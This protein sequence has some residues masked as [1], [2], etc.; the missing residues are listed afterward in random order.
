MLQWNS[1]KYYILLV[2]IVA[3]GNQHAMH[4][5]LIA[6]CALPSSTFFHIIL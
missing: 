5:R 6:I 3:L 4:M 2:Y 1:N